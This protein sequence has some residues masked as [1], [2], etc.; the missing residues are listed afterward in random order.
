MG[1]HAAVTKRKV[2]LVDDHPLLRKGLA[3][4][5]N[6]EKDLTVCGEADDAG[7]AMKL[8]EA[9]RPDAAVVDITLPDSS[10]IELIKNI[11]LRVPG[12]VVLVLSMHD[13]GVYAERVLRAGAR[14]YVSKGE[15]PS[16]VIEGIRQVLKG[17]VFVSEKMSVRML[18]GLVGARREAGGLP[19][20]HLTDREFEVLEK[21][22]RGL[23][24]REIAEDL[25]L[26]AKTVDAHR[27]NLKR[28]LGLADAAELRKY[29]VNWVQAET[30]PEGPKSG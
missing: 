3:Q 22:G 12:T 23:Q 18:Q 13:E 5:I 11:R 9:Q 25:H 6:Q 27:E 21:I 24:V 19:V 17:E 26:S 15:S 14:G 29:A 7:T 30:R 16:R 1:K 10:G 28:K 4:L 20:D 8:I 2:L